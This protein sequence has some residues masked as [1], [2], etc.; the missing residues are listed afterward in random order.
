MTRLRGHNALL[1]DK[2]FDEENQYHARLFSNVNSQVDEETAV[3]L[4]ELQRQ[5]KADEETVVQDAPVRK[6]QP[7]P[8]KAKTKP[9]KKKAKK[10]EA[11]TDD[12][13]R[14]DSDKLKE[15]FSRN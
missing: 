1:W 12:H 11:D 3:Q 5:L 14:I 2:I 8:K 4:K 15:F 7:K 9:K 6:P 13:P 10:K